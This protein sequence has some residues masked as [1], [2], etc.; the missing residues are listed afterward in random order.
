MIHGVEH[1]LKYILCIRGQGVY[2]H[3]V[4]IHNDDDHDLQYIDVIIDIED[5]DNDKIYHLKLH[6]EDIDKFYF[7]RENYGLFVFDFTLT[8]Y[9]NERKARLVNISFDEVGYIT[10]GTITFEELT[11]EQLRTQTARLCSAY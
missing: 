6:A 11:D 2:I 3:D 1:L 7:E 4:L 9:K 10:A 5:T 8:P